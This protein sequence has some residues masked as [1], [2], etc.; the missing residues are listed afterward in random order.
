MPRHRIDKTVTCVGMALPSRLQ[1]V[2]QQ[3]QPGELE[4]VAQVLVGPVVRSAPDV[5]QKWRQPQ[6][7]VAPG[8]TRLPGHRATRFRRHVSEVAGRAGG[9]AAVEVET[10]AE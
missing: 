3:E 10:K 7:P 2:A 6:Q 1:D 5:A 4:T 9:G 8:L